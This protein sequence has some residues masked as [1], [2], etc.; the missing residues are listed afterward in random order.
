MSWQPW[1]DVVSLVELVAPTSCAGCGRRGQRWCPACGAEL[2]TPA[3][4]PWSPTP[5][6]AGMPPTWSGPPYADHVRL[7]IV[8]WKDQGRADLTAV[9]APVLREIL[10][11][12]LSASAPHRDHL[13]A[14]GPLWL[15]PAPSARSGTRARGEHRVAAL[16][17][18]SV[19][20][21]PASVCRVSGALRLRR[22]VSDQAGLTALARAANLSGAV[23]VDP[24]AARAMAGRPCVVVDDVVTTGATLAEC[25]R[26]LRQAG[27]GPVIAVTLAATRRRGRGALPQPQVAD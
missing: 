19:H 2:R 7:A 13:R 21:L 4:G 20:D 22:R 17:K 14:G 10:A 8:A 25:A 23:A 5:R 18:A 12:A 16:T 11:T 26:A 9:F 6:P 3:P 15:L 27:F 1:E 24:R